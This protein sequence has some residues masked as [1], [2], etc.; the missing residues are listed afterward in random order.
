MSIKCQKIY[1]FNFIIIVFSFIL[2]TLSCSYPTDN[3]KKNHM[4]KTQILFLHHSTGEH[5]WEGGQTDIFSKIRKKISK[6]EAVSHWFREYNKKYHKNYQIT[7]QYFPTASPYGWNNYPFDYYN[8]WVKHAGNKL[9]KEEPTLEILTMK[10]NVIIWK[11]CFPVSNIL[12]DTTVPN[13]DSEVKTLGNYKL[14]YNALKKKMHEFSDTKFIIWTGAALVKGATT[15]KNATR[16]REFF[17]WVRTQWNEP[18]DN[19][20]LWDFYQ[21]ETES[22]LYMKDEYATGKTNS[23][24]NPVFSKKVYPLFCKRI[25]DIIEKN[26]KNTKLTGETE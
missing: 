2:I 4:N 3:T 14:Q 16:A 22:G 13:I 21:L 11:H 1:N 9:F 25:T 20:Y 18:G 12:P 8:I 19:I 26:G 23:H 5:I 10:Y 15:G 24:P 7:D 6:E 17:S